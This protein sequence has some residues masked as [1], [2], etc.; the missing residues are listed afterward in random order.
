MIAIKLT[1]NDGKIS[2]SI[3]IKVKKLHP[4]AIIPTYGTDGAACFDLYAVSNETLTH[5]FPYIMRTGLAFDLP[6]GWQLKVYSRN[7]VRLSNSVAVIDSDYKG[8]L[9]VMLTVDVGGYL[10]IKKGDRIAQAEPMPIIKAT[11]EEVQELSE[12][13]R[14]VGGFGST[15]A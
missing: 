2:Q 9:L 7:R 12:T 5:G 11:F 14:G 3:P 1:E 4:D 6:E 15:G 8:E 13:V 10:E